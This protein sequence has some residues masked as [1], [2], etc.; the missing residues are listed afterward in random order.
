MPAR[1]SSLIVLL[2]FSLSLFAQADPP[3]HYEI[4]GGYS[5]LSNSFNG[6]PGSRQVLNG[7][8]A[9][10]GF[11]PWRN[12]RF[13]IE[14]FGYNGNNLGAQQHAFF[15]MG[16][17][18]YTWHLRNESV[19]IEGLGGDG[20]LNRYWGPN[21][22]PGEIA[23]FSSILGGGVDTP[24]SR[25]FAI[26]VAADYQWENFALIQSVN[27][28]LPYRP[29]GC[30]IIS[31][32][33]LQGLSGV[34]RVRRGRSGSHT[35]SHKIGGG[36]DDQDSSPQHAHRSAG[37]ALP[38]AQRQAHQSAAKNVDAHVQHPVHIGQALR[39]CWRRPMRKRRTGGTT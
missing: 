23:S 2:S 25:H 17:G 15:L 36:D 10:I 8:D 14:S 30:P 16:G 22:A 5:L 1:I 21:Q 19:F 3:T 18:Q 12:L 6:V 7:W 31:R 26:R 28:T 4:Y 32:A 37:H 35:Q 27:L 33:F 11:P 20:G 9:S 24:I 38:L 13:K 39:E 34:S 29:P